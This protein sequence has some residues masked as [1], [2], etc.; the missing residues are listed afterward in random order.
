MELQDDAEKTFS[1]VFVKIP[2]EVA[3][4]L[5]QMWDWPCALGY[6][7]NRWAGSQQRQKQLLLED[8]STQGVTFNLDLDKWILPGKDVPGRGNSLY[9]G[10]PAISSQ[11]ASAVR[12]HRPWITL[13]HTVCGNRGSLRTARPSRIWQLAEPLP[14]CFCIWLVGF[15]KISCPLAFWKWCMYST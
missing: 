7:G 11:Q 5:V 9:Q 15:I 13:K 10:W 12:I 2:H 6:R 14:G 8:G 3:G 1:V 4:D